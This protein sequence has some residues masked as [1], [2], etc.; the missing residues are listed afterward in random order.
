[1]TKRLIEDRLLAEEFQ[2]HELSRRQLLR[3]A[4][5]FATAS[6]LVGCGLDGTSSDANETEPTGESEDELRA[7]TAVGMGYHATTLAKAIDAA[8][9]ESRGLAPIRAGDSV[10]LKV[11]TNSGDLYP[12]STSAQM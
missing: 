10:Y 11:N 6:A 12:Y 1:M 2:A 7:R 4:F 8:L 9:S 5:G 3:G